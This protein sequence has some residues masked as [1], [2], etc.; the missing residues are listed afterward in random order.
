MASMRVQRALARA[1]VDSRR[2]AEELV[3]AGRVLVNG[4][5]AHIG[6]V[7]DPDTDDIQVDERRL[8]RQAP[9]EWWVLNK[10]A[11]V[12]VTRSDPQGRRTVFDLVADRPGLTYVGRLDYLTEG[13][14][15]LTTDGD[16][17][18]ALTHPSR[19]VERTYVASVRGRAD[20]AARRARRGVILED[21]EVHLREVHAEP[22]GGGRW[23]FTITLA[24]GRNREVR[25]LCE[26]LDLEVDR[27]VRVQHGPVLLGDLPSGES[28]RLSRRER[29]EIA[30]ITAG[31]SL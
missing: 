18:H 20:E 9:P 31:V 23:E 28:R 11:G 24:E 19:E 14:L 26:A 29:D 5:P 22:V 15:L 6:Q 7:V 1:G 8:P 10:P 30:A 16:A 17:A 13:V 21:G 3:A 2:K 4:E 12:L 25:R 27:L